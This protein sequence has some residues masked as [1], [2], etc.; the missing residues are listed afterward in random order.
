MDVI[1]YNYPARG[2]SAYDVLCTMVGCEN[3]TLLDDLNEELLELWSDWEDDDPYFTELTDTTPEMTRDW[4]EME[5]SLQH[6]ARLV[7]PIVSRVLQNVFGPIEQLLGAGQGSAFVTAGPG[8]TIQFFQRARVFSDEDAIVKALKHPERHLGPPPTG[9]GSAGRM[10]VKGVSV[11]YGATDE[12]TAIAEVRPPVGS[13]VVTAT[14]EITQSLRLLNLSD[15][16]RVQ[17]D[18]RLSYFDPA[19]MEQ[20]QRCAFLKGLKDRLLMPVMPE[21]VDQGYL[22]TQAIADFL[23][24]HPTLNVDGIYFPSV[25]VPTIEDSVPGHNV[26]LFSKACKVAKAESGYEASSVSLWVSDDDCWRYCPE[27]WAGKDEPQQWD[28]DWPNRGTWQSPFEPRLALDRNR[29]RIHQV[30]SVVYRT[31]S[32]TV[33]YHPLPE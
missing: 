23:S 4:Y 33:E 21:L 9:F 14:F 10:N 24:T 22:I 6:E 1:H 28:Y 5:R 16:H 8:R 20:A 31:E 29:I 26:I 13:F 15:L 27:M 3:D 12:D 18:D 19:R 11:F 7:N 32:E 25:Q 30:K 2:R 17:P